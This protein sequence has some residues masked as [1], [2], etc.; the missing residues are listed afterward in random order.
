[1]L[2]IKTLLLATMLSAISTAAETSCPV[3]WLSNTFH[4]TKC[5]AGTMVID[6]EGAY[7][8]V[9]D[10]RAYKEAL[11]NTALLYATATTTGETNWSTV[12]NTCVAKVR[13]TASDYS[14]Q[15]SSAASKAEATP[16]NDSTSQGTTTSTTASGASS[17]MGSQ[18]S[19]PTPTSNAATPLATGGEVVFGGVAVAAAVFM[20]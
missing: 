17:G 15:V 3:G 9:E 7:C 13:F 12:E 16:T 20:L 10:M 11:T 5:C 4:G 18:T 8:C 6:E 14:A 1:M 2:S 19:S